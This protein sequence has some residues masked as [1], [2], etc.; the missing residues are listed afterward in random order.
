MKMYLR[1]AFIQVL[2]IET[3]QEQVLFKEIAI[4]EDGGRV[5]V[6]REPFVGFAV[7]G[8]DDS[9]PILKNWELNCTH[10]LGTD[11]RTL[12]ARDQ[13]ERLTESELTSIRHYVSFCFS[14]CRW[15]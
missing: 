10:I 5:C 15:N 7:R 12:S 3:A 13:D 9:Y 1:K 8:E 11:A 6:L 4:I 14:R 2:S